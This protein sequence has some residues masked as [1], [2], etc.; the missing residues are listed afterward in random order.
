M[1]ECHRLP[2]GSFTQKQ[3][4]LLIALDILEKA[5]FKYDYLVLFSSDAD[6]VPALERA[7][8]HGARTIAIM[9]KDVPAHFTKKHI[10]E[11][12]YLEDILEQLDKE[13][14]IFRRDKKEKAV[15]ESEQKGDN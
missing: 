10:N 9:S 11:V 8:A 1:G 13:A 15:A 12:L 4:D 3:V 2:D 5:M 14:L 7:K 6:F